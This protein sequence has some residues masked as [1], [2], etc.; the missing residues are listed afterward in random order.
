[1]FEFLVG[2]NKELNE[3]CGQILAKETLPSIREVFVKV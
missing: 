1:M 2:L 3:V